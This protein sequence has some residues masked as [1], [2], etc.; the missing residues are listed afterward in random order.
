MF[1]RA[2]TPRG[3]GPSAPQFLGFLSIYMYSVCRKTTKYHTVT[4]MGYGLFLD[5]QPRPHLKGA[6]ALPNLGVPFYLCVHSL[7]Q[8]YQ[9]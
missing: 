9:I 1:T 3:Q 4:H 7:S 5:V 8:N 6:Q 2:H